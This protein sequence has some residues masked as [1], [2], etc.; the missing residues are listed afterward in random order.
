MTIV[1]PHLHLWDV[2]DNP[3]QVRP[4]VRLAGWNRRLLVTIAKLAFPKD[5]IAFFGE[6]NHAVEDYL[7][8]DYLRD[9]RPAGI[10]RYV[11]VQ[12]GW[13]DAR[14]MDPVGETRWL[15]SLRRGTASGLAGIVGYADLQLG[16]RVRDVLDAHR[17]ASPA[18]RG[19]R[20][21]LAWH[22]SPMVHSFAPVPELSR[23][24]A[25]RRGFEALVER[26]L[27][28][29][30]WL[31]HS[32]LPE[33]AA[34]AR[35]FPEARIVL[36]HA[37]TPVGA[38]GPFHGLGIYSNERARILDQWRDGIAEVAACPNVW[39]KISGLTMPVLGLGY[40]EGEAKP[41]AQELAEVIA[42][43]AKGAL[44]AFGAERC[45]FASNFPVDKV[46][47]DMQTLWAAYAEIVRDRGEDDR[48][49]LFA[50][51]ATRFYRLD[52]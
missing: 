30:A 40:H 44:D 27:T 13:K 2:H 34:L 33:L 39:C 10:E 28:Y 38:L 1:D 29:D 11:H 20:H 7:P 51:N 18:F 43:L 16:E 36:C 48:R 4:L 32:Q 22:E 49:R 6:R 24:R 50:E 5:L 46:S 17:A 42:P 9:A 14:P 25:W 21:T 31:Y 47:V 8:D 35:D 41:G 52:D 12:A 26:G 19:I 3:R 45:M 37:G 23:D 15:E